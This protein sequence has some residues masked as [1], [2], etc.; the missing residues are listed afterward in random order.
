MRWLPH[1][2]SAEGSGTL[3][4]S[5]RRALLSSG[6]F[7]CNLSSCGLYALEKHII[8][9]AD[10]VPPQIAV[11]SIISSSLQQ[12]GQDGAVA[13]AFGVLWNLK[14]TRLPGF[15]EATSHCLHRYGT[16]LRP[17]REKWAEL[18]VCWRGIDYF[19][20]RQRM[21]FEPATFDPVQMFVT[22]KLFT[23]AS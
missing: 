15:R 9:H 12:Q 7:P 14:G 4:L 1:Y 6:W 20:G 8:P 23:I 17:C 19:I 5:S 18:R 16:K 2:P 21:G 13:A 11:L 22:S 10:S 3:T